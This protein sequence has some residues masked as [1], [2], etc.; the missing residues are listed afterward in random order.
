MDTF[1]TRHFIELIV[2][3]ILIILNELKRAQKAY[4]VLKMVFFIT[5][6]HIVRR[7]FINSFKKGRKIKAFAK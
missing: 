3:F 1:K 7:C 2:L 4:Y 6:K 5:L